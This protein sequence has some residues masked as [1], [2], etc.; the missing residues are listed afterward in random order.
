MIP[1]QISEIFKN[2]SH[3]DHFSLHTPVCAEFLNSVLYCVHYICLISC[4]P[5]CQ[6]SLPSIPKAPIFLMRLSADLVILCQINRLALN[7]GGS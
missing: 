4:P 5:T 2:P 3:C 1:F 7:V 6:K